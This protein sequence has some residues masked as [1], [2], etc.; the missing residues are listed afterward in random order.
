M[1]NGGLRRVRRSMPRGA[2]FQPFRIQPTTSFRSPSLIFSAAFG[3]IGIGPQTPAPPLRTF[4]QLGDGIAH[5]VLRGDVLEGRADQLLVHRV[6]GHAAGLLGSGGR[7]GG[8]A[9]LPLAA[10]ASRAARISEYFIENSLQ[11]S[12]GRSRRG[13][14][15][16]Q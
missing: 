14:H 9:L 12:A 11:L 8:Q 2:V 15:D 5:L 16:D 6:A 3:G 13:G 10:V 1:K 4:G 7:V